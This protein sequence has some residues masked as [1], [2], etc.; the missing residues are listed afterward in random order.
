MID[1]YNAMLSIDRLEQQAMND[2]VIHRLHPMAKLITTIVYIVIVI[3]FPSQNVSGLVPL[4]FYPVILMS[5]SDTPYRPLLARLVI[6]LPFSLAGGISNLF[7]VRDTMFYIGS[8]AVSYGMVSFI[9]I[10]LKTLFTVMAVLLLIA[11]TSFV[12]ISNQL[13]KLHVPKILCLQFVM[14]YRYLS[15]LLDEAVSMF[16][17]YTLRAPNEKEIKMKDMSSFLGQLI[18]RSFDHSDNIYKAMKCRGFDGAYYSKTQNKFSLYDYIYTIAISLIILFLRLFNL[19]LFLGN[20][21]G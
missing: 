20:L 10:I 8:F 2:S 3:S 15:V 16:T 9:S 1:L 11:T 21:I 7:F 5:L 17:A 18:L 4:I 13:V 14:M 12:E 19:S 6:A